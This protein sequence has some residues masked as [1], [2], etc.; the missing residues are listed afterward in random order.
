MEQI[1]SMIKAS[2]DYVV[3]PDGLDDRVHI[4]VNDFA[5]GVWLCLHHD[6]ALM[7]KFMRLQRLA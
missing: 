1:G 2:E 4:V 6:E 7:S 3:D 5:E